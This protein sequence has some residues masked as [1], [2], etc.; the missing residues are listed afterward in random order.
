MANNQAEKPLVTGASAER[1]VE[2][3]GDRARRAETRVDGARVVIATGIRLDSGAQPLGGARQ[4]VE[5]SVANGVVD[6]AGAPHELLRDHFRAGAVFRF[7]GEHE[8]R[9][10]AILRVLLV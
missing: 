9:I 1:T 2:A 4:A 3:I 6:N 7:R 10:L 5:I 8:P